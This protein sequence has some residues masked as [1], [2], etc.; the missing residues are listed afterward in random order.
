MGEDGIMTRGHQGKKGQG[1]CRTTRMALQAAVVATTGI[2]CI[3]MGLGDL[4]LPALGLATAIGAWG[5]WCLGFYPA[6]PQ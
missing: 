4:E 5:V 2:G 3:Y 6:D 1:V